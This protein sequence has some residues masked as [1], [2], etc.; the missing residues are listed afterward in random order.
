MKKILQSPF[1]AFVLI[2]FALFA[3]D[4][5]Y[6]RFQGE[7]AY[8]IELT[9]ASLERL[10]MLYA[11]QQ[12]RDVDEETLRQLIRAHVEE[13]ALSREAMRRGLD[14]DDTIIRR[15][16]AQKMKFIIEDKY[17]PEPIKQEE[18]RAYYDKNKARYATPLLLSFEHIYFNPRN[19]EKIYERAHE[20][21]AQVNTGQDWR[22]TGDPFM[23]ERRYERQSLNDINKNFGAHFTR[24]IENY[25]PE[26]NQFGPPIGSAYGLHLVRIIERQAPIEKSFDEVRDQLM[27]DLK[28]EK[29]LIANQ[30][31]IDEVIAKYSVVFQD[32]PND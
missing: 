4:S 19:N 26:K 17:D 24:E 15:R 12:N 8:K 13:Q 10:A 30:K 6:Q 2:G 5:A 20:I 1:F 27:Q 7:Q 22:E 29:R 28:E 3:I 18:L 32:S 14:E 31:A 16:L 25:M 21:Q 11:K 23:L 9:Q